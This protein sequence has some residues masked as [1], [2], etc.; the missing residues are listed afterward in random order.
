MDK[1]TSITTVKPRIEW[2]DGI[3]GISC[4]MLFILH[5][6]MG[7][8]PAYHF[9]E[10]Q[11]SHLNGFEVWLLNSPLN[12]FFAGNVFVALFCM[13]SGLV[14]A[15]QVMNMKNPL[16]KIPGVVIKRYLRLMLPVVPIGFFV[17]VV[18][19]LGLFYNIEAVQ[20]TLSGWLTQYYSEDMSLGSML[21]AVFVK[22]WFY[23]DDSIS[24]AYWMLSQ[25]FYGSFLAIILGTIYWQFKR[26]AGALYLFVFAVFLPRHDYLAAF[27]VGAIIAWMF[28]EGHMDIFKKFDIKVGCATSHSFSKV[29]GWI[30]IALGIFLGG[31]PSGTEPTNYYRIMNIHF[32]EVWYFLG[33]F[34]IIFGV[35][36]LEVV[37]KFLNIRPLKFLAK[38]CYDIFLVH[39]PII[40]SAGMGLFVLLMKN[41]MDYNVAV[42]I[43]AV[44]TIPLV[45][46]VSAFYNKYVGKSCSVVIKKIMDITEQKSR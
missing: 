5:F 31:Y 23:G 44:V 16:E 34:F 26:F 33:A 6:F 36:Q 41:G 38:I 18:S 35:Y 4:L 14:L 40:F 8:Y 12:M 46:I 37:Q 25:M 30:C 24:T 17:W 28:K 3:K 7:F 21:S 2:L 9:G 39:I 45:V 20:Y 42:I 11:E 32:N 15:L 19:K 13:I 29:I 1:V 27:A 10:A 43:T 22:I